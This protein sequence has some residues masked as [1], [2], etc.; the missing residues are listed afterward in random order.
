MGTVI[1]ARELP[2]F[3]GL[4]QSSLIVYCNRDPVIIDSA[5]SINV[6][7]AERLAAVKPARRALRIEQCLQKE[8]EELPKGA[9]IKDF[10]VMFHPDYE[11]DVLRILLSQVRIR[12][13]SV[14]W[15]GRLEG[16]ELIYAEEDFR[17]YKVFDISNYDVTCVI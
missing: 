4:E 16:R 12:S 2:K 5:V 6:P 17:D 15:P 1:K 10:D 14:L 11:I 7:L 13:F 3:S 8:L 9:I